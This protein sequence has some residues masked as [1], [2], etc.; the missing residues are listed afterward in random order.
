MKIIGEKEFN[1]IV[2]TYSDMITRI[3]IINTLNREDSQDCFQNTFIKLYQS[4][5]D[6]QDENHLKAWLITV[7][8][9][10]CHN[11]HRFYKRH[12]D[13]EDL[14]IKSED[15]HYEIIDEV[16][17]LP[18]KQR[19]VLYLHYYEGYLVKEIAKILHMKENTVLSHLKR[20]KE[21][22]KKRLGDLY[23]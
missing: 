3:C 11:S 4:K 18:V 10:E 21:N 6:F 9:H 19:N 17:K 12:V 14:I 1:E 8:I 13:Y 15:Q 2:H 22:L 7:A 5:K 23:E 20:G 16:M